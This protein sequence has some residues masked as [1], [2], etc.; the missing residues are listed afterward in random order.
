MTRYIRWTARVLSVLTFLFLLLFFVG[1]GIMGN[2]PLIMPSVQEWLLLIWFPI[3]L[4]IGLGLG[5]RDEMWG[6]LIGVG[7]MF[8]FYITDILFTG[9]PPSGIAFPLLALPAFL[10]LYLGIGTRTNMNG[11]QSSDGKPIQV[12]G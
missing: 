2:D 12:S 3:G 8:L 1:E 4:L 9:T 7:S 11:N 5:W 6:G 10:F